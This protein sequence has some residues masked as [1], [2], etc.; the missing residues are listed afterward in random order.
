MS[1]TAPLALESRP[2]GWF[3]WVARP[4]D[5]RAPA[6]FWCR[7]RRGAAAAEHR[8]RLYLAGK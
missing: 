7:P 4:A 3:A 2:D 1:N 5:G 8:A 6:E